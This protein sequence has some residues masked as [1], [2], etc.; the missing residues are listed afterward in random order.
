M[1]HVEMLSQKRSFIVKPAE[2]G[3]DKKGKHKDAAAPAVED[4][5]GAGQVVREVFGGW[6]RHHISVNKVRGISG[7]PS[8]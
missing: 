2:A 3:K 1:A 7:M 5:A 8:I 4:T 6:C